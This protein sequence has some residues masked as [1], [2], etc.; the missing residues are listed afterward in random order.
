M[1]LHTVLTNKV[2]IFRDRAALVAYASNKQTME[3]HRTLES[4]Q[5]GKGRLRPLY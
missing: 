4:S 1:K 3:K 5:I 2:V